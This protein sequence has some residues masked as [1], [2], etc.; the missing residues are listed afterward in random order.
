M[1]DMEIN[2]EVSSLQMKVKFLEKENNTLKI[3]LQ[4]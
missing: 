3:K 2:K 1:S 4:K